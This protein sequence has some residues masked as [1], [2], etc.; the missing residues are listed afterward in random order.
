V[1][2]TM[3]GPSEE[4]CEMV[5]SS[6]LQ[7]VMHQMASDADVARYLHQLDSPIPRASQ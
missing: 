1:K 5:M 2:K 3:L 6:C 7:D 4:H